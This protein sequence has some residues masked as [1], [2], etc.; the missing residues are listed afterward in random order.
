MSE[1]MRL[2]S[3]L[4]RHRL[5]ICLYNYYPA[6]PELRNTF[7]VEQ[8][9]ARNLVDMGPGRVRRDHVKE[10]V[11]ALGEERAGAARDR[12]VVPATGHAG[13][14]EPLQLVVADELLVRPEHLNTC[15]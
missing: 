3:L 2:P 11:L 15:V 13:P 5:Q 10:A 9:I 7:A 1:C 14:C 12:H 4:H 8:H 6:W